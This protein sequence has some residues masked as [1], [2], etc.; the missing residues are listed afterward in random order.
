MQNLMVRTGLC[1]RLPAF[2][3]AIVTPG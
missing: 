2:V 3:V 1:G